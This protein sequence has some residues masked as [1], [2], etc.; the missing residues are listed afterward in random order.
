V[1]GSLK[2]FLDHT[3]RNSLSYERAMGG[4]ISLGGER[5]SLDGRTSSAVSPTPRCKSCDCAPGI[6]DFPP[7]G[8]AISKSLRHRRLC[9]LCSF[10]PGRLS[11][12]SIGRPVT[13]TSISLASPI[14]LDV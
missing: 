2:S 5:Q 3:P 14:C 10:P 13:A 11:D 7:R 6:W 4:A 12:D 8:R 1:F 9:T